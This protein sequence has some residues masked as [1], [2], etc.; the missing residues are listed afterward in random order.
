MPKGGGGNC[1][2]VQRAALATA[3]EG[4]ARDAPDGVGRSNIG[5]GCIWAEGNSVFVGR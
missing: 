1:L 5:P 2:T 4:Y 3:T